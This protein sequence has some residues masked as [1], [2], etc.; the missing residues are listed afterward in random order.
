MIIQRRSIIYARLAGALA[1]GLAV[2][3]PVFKSSAA[4]HVSHRQHGA[5]V[6]GTAQ[7]N[8]AVDGKSVFLE[9]DSPAMNIIGFEHQPSTAEQRGAVIEAAEK[10]EDG[11]SLFAF[12]KEAGCTLVSVTIDSAL[13]AH[14]LD[15]G[16]PDGKHR[17]SAAAGH[18]AE[19][20]SAFAASYQFICTRP[21]KLKALEVNLFTVFPGFERIDTQILTKSGQKGVK[22]S[23]GNNRVDL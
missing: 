11:G 5:H 22:L 1:L 9:L 19:D 3:M 14:G 15:E 20:H 23:A 4:D 12:S 21:K 7:M 13:L 8:L 10:L 18:G 2:V 6:H 16:A 17:H